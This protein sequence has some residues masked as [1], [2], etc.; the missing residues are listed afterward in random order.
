MSLDFKIGT[1]GWHNFETLV[2]T[3]LKCIIG[4]GVSTLG[5]TKDKGRDASFEGKANYPSEK[6]NWDGSWIFQV[7]YVDD[8]VGLDNARNRVKYNIKNEFELIISRNNLER[9]PNNYILITNVPLTASNRNEIKDIILDIGYNNNFA[10]ID[11]KEICE[12]LRKYPVIRKSYPQ[13]LG[14][15]DLDTIINRDVYLQSQAYMLDWQPKLSTFVKTSPYKEALKK[16]AKN[17]F[18]VLDG[19]PEAGKSTIAAALALIYASNGF[20][21][22]DIR[23]SNQFFKSYNK[24][25]QQLF[26]SDDAVGEV[27]HIPVLTENWSK[28]LSGILKFLN[29][30]HF[31]IWTTRGY[32]LEEAILNSKFNE[33]IDNFPGINKVIVEVDTIS[34]IEKAEILYNHAKLANLSVE[35]KKLIRE[36]AN[37]IIRHPN[38]TPERVR[39]LVNNF[40]L[41]SDEDKKSDDKFMTWED[42]WNFLK[43]PGD[44]WIKAYQTLEKSQKN[45]LL[46]LLDFKGRG[47]LEDVKSSYITRCR[48][49]GFKRDN[50]VR[51]LN[52]LEHS[53]IKINHTFS[54]E[55]YI[56]FQHPSLRDMLIKE[57]NEDS[58]IKLNYIKFASASG[59]KNISDG[60]AFIIR[61][62]KE[63]EHIIIPTNDEEF[64]I[65]FKRLSVILSFSMKSKLWIEFFS[66][67]E[68]IALNLIEKH[69][70]KIIKNND[71]KF[72]DKNYIKL[73]N[74]VITKF[75]DACTYDN[76]NDYS[77]YDW[78]NI[79]TKYFNLKKYFDNISSPIFIK[80]IIDLTYSAEPKDSIKLCNLLYDYQH[81][82]YKKFLNPELKSRWGDFFIK[83]INELLE[84]IKD[85]P[86]EACSEIWRHFGVGF[87]EWFFLI[88]GSFSACCTE[89]TSKLK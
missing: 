21:I 25:E 1:I 8:A 64:D 79:L 9:L 73:V 50:F 17:Y 72:I 3:I 76:N 27:F 61:N 58:L 48:E 31:L 14:L 22:I 40:L 6:T 11:G 19:P 77:L 63:K 46:T 41:K 29:N 74:I 56:N 38:F 70:L 71:E 33:I 62:D 42:I 24:K 18:I 89:V 86:M 67:I 39:Q 84:V 37:K 23:N 35:S 32:I 87:S 47:P 45:L 57:I 75:I 82:D 65:F 15:A 34:E 30:K 69:E 55:K 68:L 51:N 2:Q 54:G 36:N 81:L 44:R 53:F 28:D 83:R 10:I 12:F 52:I 16:I 4:S 88:F 20:Q 60:L 13:L 7:K 66:S 43:N 5:G 49:L 78:F 59:L 85:I 80:R 26:I